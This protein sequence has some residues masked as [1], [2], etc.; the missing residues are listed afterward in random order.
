MVKIASSVFSCFSGEFYF[1]Y[2]RSAISNVEEKWASSV[3]QHVYPVSIFYTVAKL[4]IQWC[5][6]WYRGEQE[7][8]IVHYIYCHF[9]YFVKIIV[10]K[11]KQSVT[12]REIYSPS[13]GEAQK[14]KKWIKKKYNEMKNSKTNQTR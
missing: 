11:L 1:L 2:L 8:A 4:I 5:P 10:L 3:L 9:L 7:S 13:R 12:L 14:K 6:S